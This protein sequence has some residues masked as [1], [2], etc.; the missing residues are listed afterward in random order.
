MIDLDYDSIAVAGGDGAAVLDAT[1]AQRIASC[2]QRA[3][4]RRA[5]IWAWVNKGH[6]Y[7]GLQDALLVNSRALRI[8][9]LSDA[10]LVEEA[11]ANAEYLLTSIEVIAPYK[12]DNVPIPPPRRRKRKRNPVEIS[13]NV[14]H[15]NPPQRTEPNE[16]ADDEQEQ[17]P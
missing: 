7:V 9:R 4:E 6:P 1:P 10:V 17:Q 3:E 8:A 14:I 15:L 16:G 12:W 5:T 11:A 13:P 2:A